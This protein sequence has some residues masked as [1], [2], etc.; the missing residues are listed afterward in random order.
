MLFYLSKLAF[1]IFMPISWLILII[2]YVLFSKHEKRKKAA[3]WLVLGLLLVLTN[4]WLS[5]K[6]MHAYEYPICNID[7]L[8]EADL[9]VVL[10]GVTQ[11]IDVG[12]N[13]VFFS[14]G[15]DRVTHA[16]ELYKRQ[17][18][19]K[20]LISGGS[21]SL[22]SSKTEKKECEQMALAM[23][24]M[25]VDKTDLILED[26]S[27]N[28]YE[29][30]LFSKPLVDS[31]SPNQTCVLIT[32]AFHLPRAIK[33]FEKNGLKVRPLAV[34]FHS[35]DCPASLTDF[36]PSENALST[37][38]ILIHEWIGRISYWLMGMN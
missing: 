26:K 17:K 2:L 8:K 37:W 22:N 15:A 19:K 5:N 23:M 3:L 6:A 12:D 34:D 13:R 25:G 31:I 16:V 32:S 38:G 20:I 33:C 11:R 14:K 24:Q 7:T 4:P 35:K 36:V 18:I 1:W 9:A 30:A 29:N 27:R 21:G 10:T 28:T